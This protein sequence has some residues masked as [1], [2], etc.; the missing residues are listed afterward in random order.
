VLKSKHILLGVTGG[1][2]AYKLPLL[3]RAL[4]KRGA[5]VRVVMTESAQQFVTPLTLSTLSGNE[6]IVGT[7]P[8]RDSQKI[9]VQTWH[10]TLGEWADV[11][12]IAP[13]TANIMAKIAAGI[14]DDAVSTIALALR[15]PLVLA[16]A[17]DLDMWNHPAT[18]RNLARLKE[19]GCFVIPPET[20]ELASGLVGP[21]RLA[22][23][24]RIASRI[25]AIL[26]RS[27]RDLSGRLILI[28]AGPT[29]EPIDPVRFIGNRSSGKM[30]FALAAAA[31]QRGADVTLI[32]GPVSLSTPINVR[33][34]DV[35]TADRMQ[36]AVAKE[37]PR[38]D[39]LI[40]A[41][42]VADF[43]PVKVEPGKIKKHTT[44]EGLILHLRETGD[45]LKS[46]PAGIRPAT[47]VGFALET[48]DGMRNAQRKL[49]EKKLD[50][51][52]LNHPD[53][54]GAGIGSDLNIVTLIPKRGKPVR[55]PRLTKRDVADAILDRIVRKQK[56]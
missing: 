20:G 19:T 36:K 24:S 31:A 56:R 33:R 12:L 52:V 6:V 7:F 13:A 43:A 49:R 2:A 41:A 10:I 55:L 18:Q 21:G 11:M 38:A 54:Q 9:D 34:I 50:L 46:L 30:G 14:A 17:M 15:C 28:T 29:H 32:A 23:L 51:I 44:G 16:P 3:V 48:S 1:I 25:D 53:A 22:G 27:S 39:T 5:D 40:M 37:C 26:D 47:V 45:I 35:T 8:P 42:A 4:R